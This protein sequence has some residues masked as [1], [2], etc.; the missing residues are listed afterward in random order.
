MRQTPCFS[1]RET[2]SLQHSFS[3]FVDLAPVVHTSS[4]H[5][6]RAGVPQI[7]EVSRIAERRCTTCLTLAFADLKNTGRTLKESCRDNKQ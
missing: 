6:T 4:P 7:A 1:E 2:I 3:V 5:R